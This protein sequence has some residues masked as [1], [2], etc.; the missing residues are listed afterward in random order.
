MMIELNE[1][2]EK[3]H[4]TRLRL[5]K[6]RE[7]RVRDKYNDGLITRKVLRASIEKLREEEAEYLKATRIILYFGKLYKEI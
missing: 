6:T 2:E 3:D 7:V 5:F 4:K 1:I